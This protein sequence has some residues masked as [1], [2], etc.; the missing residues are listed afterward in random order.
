MCKVYLDTS[1]IG[2][3]IDLNDD[4]HINALHFISLCQKEKTILHYSNITMDELTKHQNKF[5]EEKINNLLKNPFLN[6][7]VIDFSNNNKLYQEISNLAMYYENPAPRYSQ[8]KLRN[9][10][11]HVALASIAQIP[12]IISTNFGDLVNEHV[13][14]AIF[15]GNQTGGYDHFIQIMDFQEYNKLFLE[16]KIDHS[17]KQDAVLGR[18]HSRHI[19]AK[20]RIKANNNALKRAYKYYLNL[21]LKKALQEGCRALDF[22]IEADSIIKNGLILP[23]NKLLTDLIKTF[24]KEDQSINNKFFELYQ[25]MNN[26]TKN[27][28]R[29]PLN[30]IEANIKNLL[31]DTDMWTNFFI[32]Y[33]K[34]LLWEQAKQTYDIHKEIRKQLAKKNI[35]MFSPVP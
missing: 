3:A 10:S 30:Q 19:Q 24:M 7:K 32:N 9:D 8:E 26:T 21:N 4:H 15:K 13:V 6:F 22:L 33:H 28:N 35:P 5:T 34:S 17:T 29:T 16:N 27:F 23:R 20:K 1:A 25:N 31:K 12:I 14:K 11:L 2:A 18:F